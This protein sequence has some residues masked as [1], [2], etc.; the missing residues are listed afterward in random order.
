MN[1]TADREGFVIVYPFGTGE[2]ERMLFWNAGNCCGFAHKEK[3][4]DVAF[5]RTLFDALQRQINID[6][7]RVYATGMSNG[8]MM[9]YRLGS[10]MAD[11]FAAI[12]PVAGP[13]GT[14]TCRPSQPVSVICFHGSDDEYVPVEGGVGRRS[15]TGT[16]HFSLAHT[17][18]AWV[19]AN[20]CPPKP[21][22][23]T[24]SNIH[25]DGT[26]TV[27]STYGPGRAG[28]EVVVYL[29][30]GAGHTWP[31]RP[32][33]PHYLGK[34]TYNINANDIIW[35]FFHQHARRPPNAGT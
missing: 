15:V 11:V 14:E 25:D 18:R 5:V 21:I 32:P 24:I 19:E 12:A 30:Q 17:V 29:I 9:A 16:H 7:A 31:G 27:R 28:A 4:D 10:E 6:P 26:T 23:E 35:D 3:I 2:R 22:T 34:S 20:G 8:A 33:R 13:M 1:E